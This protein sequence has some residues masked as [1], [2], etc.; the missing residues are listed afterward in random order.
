MTRQVFITK[1]ITPQKNHL[2]S[3]MHPMLELE[4]GV[5]YEL[6]FYPKA[7][8]ILHTGI[9]ASACLLALKKSPAGC[10]RIIL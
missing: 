5:R 3:S 1:D 2:G 9:G 7:M 8:C 6:S 10:S 4:R